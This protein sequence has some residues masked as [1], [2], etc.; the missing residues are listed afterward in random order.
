MI[1]NR[2]VY[3]DWWGGWW[4]PSN[5]LLNNL[6]S[7][8]A[9][10]SDVNDSHWGITA[11]AIDITWSSAAVFNGSSSYISLN[12]NR[13][14]A[15]TWNYSINFW[16]NLDNLT[17]LYFL[18]DNA[19][20]NTYQVTGSGGVSG[21]VLPRYLWGSEAWSTNTLSA[22][23]WYMLTFVYNGTNALTYINGTLWKTDTKGG[24]SVSTTHLGKRSTTNYFDGN[25]KHCWLWSKALDATD[26][27]NL[28]N[29]WTPLPYGSFTS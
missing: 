11:T 19:W 18:L 10:E 12:Q 5:W 17:N 24:S 2:R 14:A 21:K 20:D 9:L 15:T 8:Y 13:P 23:T 28:Y 25:M 29:S 27:T 6:I 16:F 22:S 7:Y 3:F 4:W 26:M 1:H